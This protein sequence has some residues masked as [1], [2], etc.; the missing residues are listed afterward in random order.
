MQE[1]GLE[2]LWHAVI[3]LNWLGLL[4]II[5]QSAGSCGMSE[6]ELLALSTIRKEQGG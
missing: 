5:P 3:S 1:H 6:L 2:L 4:L